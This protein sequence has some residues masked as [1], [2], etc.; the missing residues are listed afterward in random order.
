[1][2]FWLTFG[3]MALPVIILVA[4]AFYQCHMLEKEQRSKK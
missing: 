2:S 3:L 1:M 4:Y